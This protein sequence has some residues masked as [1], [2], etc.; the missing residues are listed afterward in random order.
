MDELKRIVEVMISPLGIM[1]VLLIGGMV[2]CLSG[3]HLRQ[4]RRLLVSGALLYLVFTFSPLAEILIRSLER[5]FQPMLVPPQE[6]GV[7]RIVV[8]SGYGEYHP[9]FPV[10]SGLSDETICRLAEGIR[11]HRLL[12]GSKVIVSGGVVRKGDKPIAGLMADFLL[13]L[14][15]RGEDILVESNSRTTY[16]NLVE[17]RRM[18]GSNPFILVTSACDLWRASAVARKLGMNPLPAPACIWALQHYP[19]RM[20]AA[21]WIPSFFR[22]FAYPAPAR[23]TRIQWAYHEYLGYL[24][25]RLLDRL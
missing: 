22:G 14:G 6:P 20:D 23:L 1:T 21:Q 17:V 2:F 12:P 8:L 19:A 3:R 13:Q 5:P 4:G 18:V 24:W 7:D 9:A 25:Y 11:L 10:T 15:T 16:E